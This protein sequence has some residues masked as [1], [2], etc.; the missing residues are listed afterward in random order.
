MG[1]LSMCTAKREKIRL[2]MANENLVPCSTRLDQDTIERIDEFVSKH[3]YWKRNTV[4]NKILWAVMHDFDEEAI[5]DMMRRSRRASE[6]VIK[7][8]QIY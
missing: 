4:I 2:I 6:H 8:Y 3:R 5:Y 1:R 7:C